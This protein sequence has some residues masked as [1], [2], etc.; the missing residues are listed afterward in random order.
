MK[1]RKNKKVVL[2]SMI[3]MLALSSVVAACGNKADTGKSTAAGGTEAPL[4]VNIMTI[5][6]TPSPAADD[7]KIKQAIEKAT[8]SKMK[9][10]WVSGNNYTDKLNVTLASGDIP[11]LIT[12]NDPF[13]SV[14]RNSVSQGAF[15]DLTPY[16]KDYPNLN[17]KISKTAWD[18]TKMQDGKNYGIPRPRPAEADSFF[19]IRKDWLDNLGMQ[20]P[21]TTDELYTVMKAFAEKDPDKNGKNDTTALAA[22]MTP[23][24]DMGTLAMIENSFTGANVKNDKWKLVD[25]KI[26]N[27]ALLPE[28]R[29]SIE[30][31][32]KMYKD[33]LLPE[34]F[35]SY[36]LS[37][38][39]DLFNGGKA[40]IIMDKAGT[41][42]DHY[43][44]LKKIDPNMKPTDFYPL[45]NMNGYN[46]KGPGFSGMISIPKSVPEAKMKRI[47][48][49]VDTWMN[50]DVFAIQQYGIEGVDYTVKDGQKVINTEQLAKDNGPDFNQIVYVADPYAS[51]T[52]V[53]FPKE[54]NDLFMKIQDD[55]AKTSVADI[56]IG[57]YSPT[58][59]KLLPEFEKK[60]QDL[61]TKIIL[62]REPITAWDNFV[63]KAKTDADLAKMSQE[64]TDAY[65]KRSAGA[66][67]K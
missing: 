55:R 20:V 17:S 40:G 47:L 23:P 56:S 4:E 7:N 25:G 18:L 15:W 66:A 12:I 38:A 14:F 49:M 42:N 30:Y 48:K 11:D 36:K 6:L 24:A 35:A 34:D 67:A 22:F 59:Q 64:M 32:T 54:A 52:K 1:V 27:T 33:K 16:I 28:T 61:K 57:L 2:G 37:Q 44:L 65:Q 31:L 26:V 58:A 9:I 63:A 5:L 10:Q 19:I 62:G 39:A 29:S 60:V 41:M 51:S 45:T 43:E 53:Y 46:P 8:N 13:T 21:T 3:L 50:D